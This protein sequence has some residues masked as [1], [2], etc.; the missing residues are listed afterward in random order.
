[1][2]GGLGKSLISNGLSTKTGEAIAGIGS[3]VGNA[4]S[5]VNPIIGG[6]VTLGSNLIGG[7]TNAGWGYKVYGKEDAQN[8]LDNTSGVTVTG[9]N[10]DIESIASTLAAAP[11]KVTY[12][13][14]W[15]TNKGKKEAAAWNNRV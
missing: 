11:N 4:I 3:T 10:D 9:S 1:M 15:F 13:N 8:Y 5:T 6:A 7:I 2:V 12:K 14:G